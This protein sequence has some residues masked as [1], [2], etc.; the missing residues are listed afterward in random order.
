[1][2]HATFTFDGHDYSDSNGRINDS[3]GQFEGEVFKSACG[4]YW[5]YDGDT[6]GRIHENEIDAYA[7]AREAL[8]DG[9]RQ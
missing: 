5:I 9:N 6:S 2:A 7:T 3:A 1:M 4:E 8:I